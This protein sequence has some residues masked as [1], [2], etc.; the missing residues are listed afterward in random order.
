MANSGK[1]GYVVL[2]HRGIVVCVEGYL[3]AVRLESLSSSAYWRPLWRSIPLPGHHPRLDYTSCWLRLRRSLVYV[4][5]ESLE[6]LL[7]RIVSLPPEL[8]RRRLVWSRLCR[9]RCSELDIFDYC[10]ISALPGFVPVR[11]RQW[12]KRIG[13]PAVIVK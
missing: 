6:E 13:S 8:A 9:W 4:L 12:A 5:A 2:Y 3:I 1:P 11:T 7:E 10:Y